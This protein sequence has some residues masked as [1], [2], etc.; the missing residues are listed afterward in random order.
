MKDYI[1]IVLAKSTK[2]EEEY[3]LSAPFT[4]GLK[5]DDIVI[6]EADT[7]IFTYTVICVLSCAIDSDEYYFIK[8][9]DH[10]FEFK[11]ITSKA[12]RFNYSDEDY[13]KGIE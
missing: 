10:N 7:G 11:R 8:K 3:Y 6:L 1:D 12:E 9:A 5:K 2:T 13:M 4:S